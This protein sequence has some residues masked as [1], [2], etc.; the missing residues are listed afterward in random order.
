M[1]NERVEFFGGG[2]LFIEEG[3]FPYQGKEVLY[4]L[5]LAGVEASC[6]GRG[7]C[8]FIKVPGYIRSW[9]NR[10]NPLGQPVSEVEGIV[11]EEDQKEVRKIL[12]DKYPGFHQIEF[13]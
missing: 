12:Q 7:G 6:C 10:V 3:R 9:R 2:Y 11:A 13:L 5:G 8:A 1:L 4:L